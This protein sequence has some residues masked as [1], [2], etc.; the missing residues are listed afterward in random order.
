MTLLRFYFLRE[1]AGP[2][3]ESGE[4]VLPA[5]RSGGFTVQGPGGKVTWYEEG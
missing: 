1:T 3:P 4:G 5:S 2:A